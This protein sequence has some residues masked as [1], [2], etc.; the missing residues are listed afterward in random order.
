MVNA[1]SSTRHDAS[2]RM[3]LQT[4]SSAGIMAAA[5]IAIVGTLFLVFVLVEKTVR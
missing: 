5:I 1:H 4:L 3:L 2:R